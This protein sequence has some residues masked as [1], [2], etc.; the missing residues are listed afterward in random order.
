MENLITYPVRYN[1]VGYVPQAP[2]IFFVDP[3][4]LDLEGSF[5]IVDEMNQ[6]HFEGRLKEGSFE[7][8]GLCDYSGE[9]L[10]S[11]DFSSFQVP[12]K[13][14]IEIVLKGGQESFQTRFFEISED[15]LFRQ[16]QANVKSFF[17]QRSGVELPKS[18]AGNWARPAAHFDECIK[19]HKMMNREGTWNAH[20]GWYDAGDY[21]KYIVNGGISVGTLLLAC[22]MW[23]SKK[24]ECAHSSFSDVINEGGSFSQPYSLKEEIRFEL[25][26]FLRMQDH[27]GG[28]FFKVSPEHWDGFVSPQDSDLLQKRLILGKSTTSS[29]NFAGALAQAYSVYRKSDAEFA[30][31]CLDASK[32]AYG[33]AV[34]HPEETWPHNTEGSGGYGDEHFDDEFFW[35][36]A[37][38]F[39]SLSEAGGVD[40]K[41]L[42]EIAG[43]LRSDMEKNPPAKAMDWRDTQNMGWALLALQDYDV[44]LRN[45]ARR[46][47]EKVAQEIISLQKQDAYGISIRRFIWGSNGEISNHALTLEIVRNWT[48]T[49]LGENLSFW[50]LEMLNFIYGRN[51]VNR[52]FVTGSAWSS[53][54]HIH[55][56]LSHAD[57]VKDP[58]PGLLSGGIN[59][60]RQDLHRAPHY[61]SGLPGH[62]YTDE[63]CSFASNE[64]AINWNSPLTA[65][66]AM[67]CR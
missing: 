19:F 1:H 23:D 32:R 65:V 12:G 63:R 26:F 28:V 51:P 34:E 45:D 46:A 54:M 20:G 6:V 66:L 24:Q 33:W 13:F 21:G 50:S 44:S 57:N 10:W 40:Q 14:A 29:L 22:S 55:H 17:F 3:V 15:W 38:L 39:C 64:T 61:F 27:D 25:D 18:L 58:I 49:L 5:K 67:H 48:E 7:H 47:L 35:A 11:G 4:R 16:L 2:K 52:S 41:L 62:S 36:R 9:N 56:R 60:D 30:K 53:P 42:A 31:R 59:C 43:Q 8:R 37:A